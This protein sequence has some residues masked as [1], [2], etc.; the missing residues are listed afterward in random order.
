MSQSEPSHRGS[1][2]TTCRGSR[3]KNVTHIRYGGMEG[4]GR[5]EGGWVLG[6]VPDIGRPPRKPRWRSGNGCRCGKRAAIPDRLKSPRARVGV[7]NVPHDR[8]QWC[9]RRRPDG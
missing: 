4:E 8:A 5:G 6:R 1:H 7:T 9:L 2:P 3:V